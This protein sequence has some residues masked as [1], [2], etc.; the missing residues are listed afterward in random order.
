MD[1]RQL[2][3]F[4]A[5]AEKGSFTLAAQALRLSQPSVS[6]QIHSL[7]QELGTTL[8]DR[9]SRQTTI[10]PSGKILYEY[11][12][13]ILKLCDEAE[14][15][16]DELKGLV[17]GNVIIGAS[18]IPGEYILPD[19]LQRFRDR[20]PGIQV[21]L[22]V[23]DTKDI[24]DKVLGNEV[25]LGVVG[26]TQKSSKLT[27]G[28]FANDRLVLIAPA[29]NKWFDDETATLEKLKTAP[30]VM[31]ESGSGTR[32]IVSQKLQQMGVA[33]NELNTVM[34]LGSTTAVKR[35]VES[36]AGV[37]IVSERAVRREMDLGSVRKLRLDGLDLDR[38]FF[39][40]CRS[41]RTLPPAVA[42]LLNFFNERKAD[43]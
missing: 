1:L 2:R 14:Q 4:C 6:F 27:F 13:K 30:F 38:D 8:F 40:V 43:L 3:A 22:L 11:A 35:A 19:L 12:R 9:Q 20:Y 15:A 26:A 7:E 18:T 36:G 23:G 5:V 31:R 28:P 41:G 17:R 24:I 37:S 16:I 10:T 29:S 25:E 34:V 21:E 33:E 39:I 42:A 32:T